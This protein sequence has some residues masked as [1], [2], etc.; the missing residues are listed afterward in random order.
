MPRVYLVIWLALTER[1]GYW[2]L[3][4]RRR[5]YRLLWSGQVVSFAGDWFATIALYTAVGDLSSSGSAIALALVAMTLPIF[6]VAPIAG[7]LIDR[8]DRRTLLLATDFART[9]CAIGLA[10]AYQADSIVGLFALTI[11]KTA[12]AGIAIPTKSAVLPTVVDSVDVPQAN[13]LSG[14][15][16][17]AMLAIGA[18]S[19]GVVTALL[20]V[21]ASFLVDAATFLVSAWF[22]ARL[23]KLPPAASEYADHEGAS[24]VDGLRYLW[25]DKYILAVATL[26]PMMQFAGGML[27]LLPIYG[28][29]VFDE[30]SG[31]MFIGILY[32][33]RGVGAIVGSLF[34]RLFLGDRPV[35]L[36]NTITG[37]FVVVAASYYGLSAAD[38]YWQ[39]A[40][41]YFVAAIGTSAIWVFSGTLLQLE[42]DPR[43]HGRVFALEFG[44]MTLVLSMSS[45]A[46]GGA[47]DLGLSID[48]IAVI[49]ATLAIVGGLIWTVSLRLT[50]PPEQLPREAEVA[51]ATSGSGR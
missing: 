51:V 3:L 12:F 21:S 35:T 18:A 7:P 11:L 31:A 15:T 23:P 38:Y 24:F 47:L 33:M 29:R 5:S 42:A 43:Y 13:A 4:R 8:F 9:A 36:R 41:A 28:S 17:S 20:G 40:I 48:T 44:V 2:A 32:M 19:G 27:A 45:L 16:W 14:G 34:L 25:S 37:M 22:F 46:A 50:T 1:G 49:L 6:L 30:A 10:L 39:A 26:K